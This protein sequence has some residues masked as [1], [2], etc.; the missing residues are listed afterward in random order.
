MT[1]AVAESVDAMVEEAIAAAENPQPHNI[2]AIVLRELD[3]ET[4]RQLAVRPLEQIA[5]NALRGRGATDSSGPAVPAGVP[6]STRWDMVRMAGETGELDPARV[7]VAVG[8]E[9]SKPLLDCMYSDLLSASDNHLKFAMANEAFAEHYRMLADA[10]LAD[11]DARTVA[12]LPEERVKA[13]LSA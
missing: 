5:R 1:T 9:E 3:E 6:R 11:D 13:I 4:L 12:D 8:E 2:V 10:L 7:Q